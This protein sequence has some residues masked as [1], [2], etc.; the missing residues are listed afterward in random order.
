M[1]ASTEGGGGGGGDTRDHDCRTF[2]E[3]RWNV[4]VMVKHSIHTH[5]PTRTLPGSFFSSFSVAHG[6]KEHAMQGGM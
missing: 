6:R 3:L 4:K 5:T 2:Q 1:K